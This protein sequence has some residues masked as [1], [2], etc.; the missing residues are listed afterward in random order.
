MKV[1]EIRNL[2]TAE[3]NEKIVSLREELFNLRFQLATGQL[4]NP[5]RIREVRKTIARIK[6]VQR[7]KELK[8]AHKAWQ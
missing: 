1:N 3:L 8:A 7:E 5:M 6:T 4:E 2:S